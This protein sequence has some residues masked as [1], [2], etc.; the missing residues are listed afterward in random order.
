MGRPEGRSTT[1]GAAETKTFDK[2]RDGQAN[3]EVDEG[4]EI[5]EPG[6][7]IQGDTKVGDHCEI[8]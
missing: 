6:D 7:L 4:D 1:Y 8:R 5:T 2:R 3:G